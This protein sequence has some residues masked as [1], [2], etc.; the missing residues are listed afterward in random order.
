MAMEV[1]PASITGK[2]PTVISVLT[3][4]T[5]PVD[6]VNSLPAVDLQAMEVVNAMLDMQGTEHSAT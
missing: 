4:V 6:V 1:A 5:V 2:E 3:T